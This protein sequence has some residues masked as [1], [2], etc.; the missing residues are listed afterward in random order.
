MTVRTTFQFASI[1]AA[2]FLAVIAM[3]SVAVAQHPVLAACV[4]DVRLWCNV[5]EGSPRRACIRTRFR[6]FSLPCQVEIVKLGAISRACQQDIKKNCADVL[7]GEDRI[8]VCLKER[9]ADVSKKC[10]ETMAQ[11][12]GKI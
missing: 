1:V 9:F 3:P 5:S 4:A 10:K 7:P 6:E 8:A 11:A 2:G 12:A